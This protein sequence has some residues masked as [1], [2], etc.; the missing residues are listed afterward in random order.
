MTLQERLIGLSIG[1]Q[2]GSL[3]HY[4]PSDGQDAFGHIVPHLCTDLETL[5]IVLMQEL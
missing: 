4:L 1:L 3:F 5:D 2:F